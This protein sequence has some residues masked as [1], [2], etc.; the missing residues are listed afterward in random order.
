MKIK[1]TEIREGTRLE[2]DGEVF[3]VV[4]FLHITPGKG[5]PVV[6]T[7]IKNVSTGRVLERTFTSTEVVERA[8]IDRKPMQF[9]YKEG[10]DYVFMDMKTYE[11]L[12]LPSEL[13]GDATHFLK[14]NSE[15]MVIWFKGRAIGV[16]LPPKVKLKVIK[17]VPGVRGD[18]VTAATKPATIETGYELQVPLFVEE[19]D[20]IVIDTRDGKY[21]ERA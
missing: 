20:V 7:K 4:S 6:R 8:E 13:L 1:A 10:N 15:I 18:T 12:S 3:E 9:L 5:R 21:V 17:T 11:Q 19:G 2:L 16:E 14:E